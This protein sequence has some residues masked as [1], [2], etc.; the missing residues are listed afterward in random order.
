MDY[1]LYV[2]KHESERRNSQSIY[3][4]AVVDLNKSE[5]Y[6]VNF[7]CMLPLRLHQGK[8]NIGSV[9]GEIF[10][11]KSLDLAMRLLKNA[12]VTENDVRVKAEIERRINMIDP[13]SA[14][15]IKCSVC[16]KSFQPRKIRKYK[17]NLCHECLTKRYGTRK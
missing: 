9:F 8:E 5:S 6:P 11:D 15:L 4:F 17:Q 10:G 14:K 2:S 1:R 7:V 3:R 12:F 16:K 13:N